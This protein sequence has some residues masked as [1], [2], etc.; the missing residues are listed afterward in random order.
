MIKWKFDEKATK[1]RYDKLK[2]YYEIHRLN[3]D[4]FKCKDVASCEKSQPNGIQNQ[5]KGGTAGLSPFYDV[6][7]KGK[8]VRV[9]IVGKESG[10]KPNET[11]RTTPNFDARNKAVLEVIYGGR[12]NHIEG[13]LDAL[14]EIFQINT[15]YIYASYALSNVLR[16]SFQVENKFTHRTAV[17]DTAQMRSNCFEYLV[18]EIKIL[19]PTV[20]ITQGSWSIQPFV[21]RLAISLGTSFKTLKTYPER[22]QGREYGL[23]KF[24]DF[25]CI[26]SHHPSRLAQWRK[27]LAPY[28]LWPMIEQLR[29]MNYLPTF[30]QN[31][32]TEYEKFVRPTIDKMFDE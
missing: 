28:S 30:E 7:Y 11:Y 12:N 14:K 22:P 26:T 1:T 2:R 13:T 6:K 24:P 18:E 31:A 8:S 17:H 3:A 20:L 5:Y 23:Y 27:N 10:Y 21:Q 19:E 25:M 32:S 16:C 9:L 29:K 15:N 4:K